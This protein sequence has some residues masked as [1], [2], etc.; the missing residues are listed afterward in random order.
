MADG[1]VLVRTADS[2]IVYANET[3]EQVLGYTPGELVDAP[4]GVVSPPE[5]EALGPEIAAA[6]AE[7]GYWSGNAR[8]VRKDG[9]RVW[10]HFTISNLQDP[11]HG[12]VTI[13]VIADI[14]EMLRVHAARERSESRL[15]EAQSV[16][17]IGSWEWDVGFDVI[18]WSAELCR[19]FGFEP[20]DHPRTYAGFLDCI[21]PDDRELVDQTVR[22]AYETL[23]LEPFEHRVVRADGSVRYVDARGRVVADEDGNPLRMI[24]TAQDVTDLR[25]AERARLE[26]EER[27]RRAFEDSGMGMALVAVDGEDEGRIVAAND[28][29]CEITGVDRASLLGTRMERLI[30]PDDLDE[31]LADLGSLMAGEVESLHS[32]RRLISGPGQEVWVNLTSSLVQSAD[33]KPVHRLVQL[34]DISERKRFENQLRYLADHDPLTGLFNRRRFTHELERELAG[35]SRY[36]TGGAV[37][38]IDLD[39]FKYINDSAGHAAGDEFIRAVANALRG[40]LRSTD[41]L[42]RL[43]GDEFGVLL[44]HT[45]RDDAVRVAENLL[46]VV[47]GVSLLTERGRRNTSASIGIAAFGELTERAS[48][49]EV[50]VE[51]DIAMY[52]AKE[53]GRDR[54]AMLEANMGTAEALDARLERSNRIRQA[55]AN[56]G[57]VLHVQPVV[58]L[59]DGPDGLP[60]FEVLLR[61]VGEDG[62][63]IP[64]AAFLAIAERF[65]LIEAIDRWVVK[66][67]IAMVAARDREGRPIAV[68]VNLSAK[69]IGKPEVVELI[70]RELAQTGVDPAQLVFEVTETAAIERVDRAK[71]FARSLRSLGCKLAIDDFGSGFATFYYLKH[72]DYDYV[73]ID[74]EFVKNLANS[75]TDQLVV[76]SLVDIARGLG[77]QTIAEFVEDAET[78][79]ALRR[80]GVDWAQGFFIGCPGPLEEVEPVRPSLPPP[81]EVEEAVRPS[82]S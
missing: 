52:E 9:T 51:A 74:G 26:A 8:A 24:G 50:L 71:D 6:L 45:T 70:E 27:F 73:K 15:R 56:D 35:S 10:C 4:A 18:E 75:T 44:P 57:F 58:P 23:S 39:N 69:S 61:M 64:P 49:E 76:R 81:G 55:L 53:N 62:D 66:H 16:A 48:A 67:A 33:G 31:H 12:E 29:M 19:I 38:V 17:H 36:A 30:H 13:C 25:S 54:F 77:K 21:H 72:L 79:E 11:V 78:I 37:L 46:E 60:C 32:E 59:G 7:K 28:A 5:N 82:P 14:T 68:S 2:R 3:F 63:L 47:R 41:C 40:K 34:Q 1:L 42:A 20:G 22:R 65:G 43:G 80:F